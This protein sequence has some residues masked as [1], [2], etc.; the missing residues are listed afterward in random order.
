MPRNQGRGRG[1]LR[2]QAGAGAQSRAVAS[3]AARVHKRSRPSNASAARPSSSSRVGPSNTSTARP[4]DPPGD[5]QDA[6]SEQD[7]KEPQIHLAFFVKETPDSVY[8]IIESPYLPSHWT[9][10]DMQKLRRFE[11][12]KVYAEVFNGGVDFAK[13]GFTA[14]LRLQREHIRKLFEQHP[15]PRDT[16]FNYKLKES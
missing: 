16:K 10:E 11:M 8:L 13:P 6:P 1:N 2:G 14:S 5:R 4:S 15:G 7:P 12:G 3:E 9:V